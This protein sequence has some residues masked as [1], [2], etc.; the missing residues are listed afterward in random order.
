MT[1]TKSP[2]FDFVPGSCKRGLIIY[3]KFTS[4]DHA[5]KQTCIEMYGAEHARAQTFENFSRF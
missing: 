3:A 1:D 2:R 4:G 5:V